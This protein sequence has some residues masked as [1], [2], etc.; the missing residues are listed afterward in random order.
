VQE[1]GGEPGQDG[2]CR[3][4]RPQRGRGQVAEAT[5]AEAQEIEVAAVAR[6][7]FGFAR[8]ELGREFNSIELRP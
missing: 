7:I 3:R 8:G 5:P 2:S 1:R 6:R 4:R